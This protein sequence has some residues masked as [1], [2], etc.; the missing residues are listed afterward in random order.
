MKF[1]MTMIV[2][3]ALLAAPAAQ[4]KKN[5]DPLT[6]TWTGTIGPDE[7]QRRPVKLEVKYDGKTITGI[8]TGPS[9]P[10]DITR[11]T[12]DAETGA[13]TMEGIIR[14]ESQT[15]VTFTGKVVNG[16]AT[17]TIVFGDNSGTFSFKKDPPAK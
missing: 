17:G 6:G 14:N 16:E 15:P 9:T 7:T 13:L 8:I 2:C 11:G 3:A 4:A 10:A 1:A 5:A 12:F